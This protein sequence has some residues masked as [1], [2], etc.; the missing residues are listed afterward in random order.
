MKIKENFVLKQVA[1]KHIVVPILEEAV[2]FNGILTLND[3]SAFL[4]NLMKTEISMD[5]LVDEVI[6]HYEI[7]DKTA[8]R[9]ITSFVEILKQ[10]GIIE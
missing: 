1:G 2:N 9:D 6:K 5:A 7:D 10:K 3:T 4:F 8:K